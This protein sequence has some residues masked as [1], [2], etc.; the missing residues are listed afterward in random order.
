MRELGS[1][2]RIPGA[3]AASSNEPIEHA[4]PMHSVATGGF[5]NCI[6]S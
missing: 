4:W 3:P 6:V 2:L 1:A 5:T